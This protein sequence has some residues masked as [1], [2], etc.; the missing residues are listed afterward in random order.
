MRFEILFRPIL[1]FLLIALSWPISDALADVPRETIDRLVD[2]SVQKREIRH[3]S[4]VTKITDQEY[5]A[6]SKALATEERTLWEPW[7]R[8]P[9]DQKQAAL[10]AIQG[11]SR[12]R[13]SVLEPRWQTEE[14]AFRQASG[15]QKQQTALAVEDNARQAT[16]FQRQRISLQQH[17]DR[18]TI[19][20]E[21]FNIKDREALAGIAALRNKQDTGQW[22]RR[23]DERLALFT[24]ALAD[25]PDTDLP[26]S[27]VQPAGEGTADFSKD[28]KLAADIV[29]TNEEN[30]Y[31]FNKKQ[32]NP[33]TYREAATVYNHDLSRLR[34]R[35]D[36]L[37]KGKEFETA[38]TRSA[39]AGIQALKMKYY[40]ERFQT[41]APQTGAGSSTW[42]W[43][44]PSGLAI[45]VIAIFGWLIV[46]VLIHM[47]D[48]VQQEQKPPMP[49]LTD[50]YGSAKW[51]D[52]QKQPSTTLSRG[53]FFG[54]SSHPDIPADAPGAPITSTPESHVL[55][56]GQTGSGKNTAVIT[57]TLL[58][59]AGSML[60]LDPKGE[61]AAITART[62][63]DQLK[64]E[65]KIL[66]PWGVLKDH[67]S[68]MG[69]QTATFNPLDVLDARDP[70][71]PSIARALA[72][73]ICPTTDPKNGFWQGSAATILSGVLLWLT[74][75]PGEQKT[76]AR[77]REIVSL[78]KSEFRKIIARMLACSAFDGEIKEAVGQASDSSAA[79]TY[80]GIMFQLQ[81]STSFIDSQ[82]KAATA[83]S[84]FS[85]DKLSTGLL[86]VYIV[87]PFKLIQTNATWLRLVISSA[88]QTLIVHSEAP[89]SKPKRRCMFMIDEFGSIGHMPGISAD[90]AQMRSAGMDFTLILQG[91]NQLKE[92]Y[93][94]A[95]D[96]ILGNCKYQYFCN[97]KDLESAKYLSETLGKKTVRTVGKSQ[98][99]G[100]TG[101]AEREGESTTYGETGRALLTPDEIMNAGK[102]CAILLPAS[103][104]PHYLRPVNYW[105]L[106]ETFAYLKNT[107]DE[108]YWQPPLSYDNNPYSS[109]ST[110]LAPP[111]PLPD[112]LAMLKKTPQIPLRPV[113]QYSAEMTP[114]QRAK[115][116]LLYPDKTTPKKPT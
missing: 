32:I 96:S 44:W 16:E 93:P 114:E 27:Q 69:F 56:F 39:A 111:A 62:R 45:A 58:R 60:V 70:N 78:P 105:D 11:Q 104:A 57:P 17:L 34:A 43:S 50:N 36:A 88:M 71:A 79:D 63:R 116:D 107:H 54:R 112:L 3:L 68:N 98:S 4:A 20:R 46:L 21:T 91:L 26:R 9:A 13:L 80:G 28:V 41:A 6:R 35:Y 18:G 37:N 51:A 75:T 66:N 14:A 99:T 86:T 94:E 24:K 90:L 31:R 55:V 89:S 67:Y 103:G 2:I 83:S 77:V 100:S 7:R 113:T 38:Y 33:E 59:Y 87:I 64:Q 15:K 22:G 49:D 47:F 106:M 74:D 25:N 82:I 53:V 40:P 10:S 109:L 84:S 108:L 115:F 92:H 110:A 76:L 1:I 95:K 30:D 73:T 52:H 29:I 97:V 8:I 81:Q 61:N 101:N 23:F 5:S 48:P 65:I 42:E 12:S 102:Q 19:D 85:I 72:A